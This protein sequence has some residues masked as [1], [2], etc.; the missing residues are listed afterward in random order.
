[1]SRA[2]VPP[3]SV[4]EAASAVG[5]GTRFGHHCHVM[6]GARVGRDCELGHGVFVA[7]GAV[8]G[9]RV[10]IGGD[11]SLYDGVVVED[12]VVIGAGAVFTNVARPRALFP[13]RG[14]FTPTLLARGCVIGPRATVVCGVR[15][16]RAAT[17]AAG[18]VVTRDV[19]DHAVVA[20]VPAR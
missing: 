6:A 20:G 10:R 9:D 11:V 15:I 16:G 4:I 2:R 1:M 13:H 8:V 14:A 3:T 5:P 7:S 17:V 18:A 19:P 12:D